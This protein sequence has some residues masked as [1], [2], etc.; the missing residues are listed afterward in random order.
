MIDHLT[1]YTQAAD[2]R[3]TGP[4]RGSLSNPTPFTNYR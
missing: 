2:S 3:S 4:H 1:T